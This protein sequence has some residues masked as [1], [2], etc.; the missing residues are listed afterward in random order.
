MTRH[1]LALIAA[2]HCGGGGLPTTTLVLDG[3]PLVVEVADD[4]AEQAR[5]LMH[6][7][8]LPADRGMVF[9]YPDLKP[10]HFWMKDTRIPLSIAFV[11]DAGVIVRIADMT[12]L[13]T[14]RTPSLYPAQYAVEVNQ[15]WFA[16]HGVEVGDKVEGLPSP[17]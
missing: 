13:S 9:V 11:D 12:P 3:T 5:G 2:V 16:A 17:P 1:A 14:K 15:G 6:R 8:T 4:P 7:D 10:R